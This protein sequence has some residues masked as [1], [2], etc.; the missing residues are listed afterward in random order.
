MLTDT[1]FI[2]VLFYQNFLN[3]KKRGKVYITEVYFFYSDNLNQDK[4]SIMTVWGQSKAICQPRFKPKEIP[5]VFIII[6]IC[7]QC[8]RFKFFPSANKICFCKNCSNSNHKN[9][10]SVEHFALFDCILFG[11]VMFVKSW[12]PEN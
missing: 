2:Q 11:C 8:N 7:S 3:L 10:V 12:A 9:L 5:R 6:I 1:F 4:I